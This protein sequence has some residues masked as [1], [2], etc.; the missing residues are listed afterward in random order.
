MKNVQI[1]NPD[2]SNLIELLE[3]N[4][5][6]QHE[7]DMT[8]IHIL[9]ENVSNE[10]GFDAVIEKIEKFR[11]ISNEFIKERNKILRELMDL[12]RGT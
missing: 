10:D 11:K 1:S 4:Y 8:L 12:K 9:E 5:D 2:F 6:M 3:K 7:L